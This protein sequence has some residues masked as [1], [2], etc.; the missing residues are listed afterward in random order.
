VINLF[1]VFCVVGAS[2]IVTLSEFPF[3]SVAGEIGFDDW[4]NE[5]VLNK[6]HSSLIPPILASRFTANPQK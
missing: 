2:G 3:V 6:R 4:L 1:C 5:A